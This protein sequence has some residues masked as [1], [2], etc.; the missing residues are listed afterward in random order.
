MNRAQ[1]LLAL[2]EVVPQHHG[3]QHPYFGAEQGDALC[4]RL[5]SL[6][7]RAVI[8]VGSCCA[9][10]G[11]G[12]TRAEQQSLA[13]EQCQ[14]ILQEAVAVGPGAVLQTR[15]SF[16]RACPAGR[17]SCDGVAGEQG[18]R[19]AGELPSVLQF[20]SASQQGQLPGQ[21]HGCRLSSEGRGEGI[22]PLLHKEPLGLL[23]SLPRSCGCTIGKGA[24]CRV[25]PEVASAQPP[26]SAPERAEL[27]WD[28]KAVFAQL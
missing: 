8:P 22:A 26:Y 5:L 12:T 14:S 25:R 23:Q 4:Q 10:R 16:S 28:L 1:A 15:L 27:E 2:A 6:R 3:V 17:E 7:G 19:C 18:C 21:C 13:M 9:R 11:E 24:L 20:R